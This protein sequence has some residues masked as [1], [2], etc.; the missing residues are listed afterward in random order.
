ME[1]RLARHGLEDGGTRDSLPL[2]MV[3]SVAGGMA[4]HGIV[5][6]DDEGM[7]RHGIVG[8]VDT[9]MVGHWLSGV[10]VWRVT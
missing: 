6:E 8:T 4:R 5:R 10:E 1:R 7:V 3:G 9:K 2:I